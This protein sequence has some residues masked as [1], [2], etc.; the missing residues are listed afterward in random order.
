MVEFKLYLYK[1]FSMKNMKSKSLRFF[2]IAL[3]VTAMLLLGCSK[4]AEAQKR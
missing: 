1:E 3:I 2:A 4:K